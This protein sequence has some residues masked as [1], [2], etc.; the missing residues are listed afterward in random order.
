MAE[1]ELL[2]AREVA[3]LVGVRVETV[4]RWVADGVLEAVRPSPR[5]NMMFRRES[6]DAL[7]DRTERAD[8]PPRRAAL[9][10]DDAY[11]TDN[12]ASYKLRTS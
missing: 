6:I 7:F 4:R 2:K 9:E 10:D 12:L 5:A 8:T 3:E 1:T 11:A